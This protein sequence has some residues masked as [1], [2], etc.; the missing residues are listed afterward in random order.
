MFPSTYSVLVDVGGTE[1]PL[2]L[3]TGSSDLWL[4]SDGCHTSACANSGVPLYPLGSLHST[5][6]DAQLLYGD[7]RTGTHASGPIGTDVTGVAG[8][9]VSGQCFAAIADTNTTVLGT[10]SA[11]IFGLGF[12]PVSV[13]WRQL[14]ETD[15]SGAPPSLSRRSRLPPLELTTTNS[16][17]VSTDG[18]FIGRPP[19]PSFTFLSPHRRIRQVKAS[20]SDPSALAIEAFATYG[21]FVTRLIAQQA[22]ASPMVAITLQRDTFE[23]GGNAGLLSLGGP[24]SGVQEDH[25]RWVPV[26]G[27][28]ADEGGLPPA[29]EA[30]NE[31][32]PLLWEIPIDDVYFDG[33]KLPRSTLSAP[34]ISLSALM[35][36]GNSLIRGPQDVVNNILAQLGGPTGSFDCDTPH[37]LSFE[38]GGELFPIDPRDFARPHTA[39]NSAN[40]PRC[41]GAVAATDPPGEGGFLYSWS[42]GDPFLK[43]VL[44]AYY[45]GNLTHPSQDPP[46][47]GFISTVPDDAGE[48]LREAVQAAISAGAIFPATS[49]PAPSGTYMATTTGPGGVPQA[50]HL[51]AS[52]S[53]NARSS[54]AARITDYADGWTSLLVISMNLGAALLG[55]ACL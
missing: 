52:Y 41:T 2:V 44:A 15:I 14:L 49:E 19:F 11:G 25:L 43:S 31:I 4:V 35:D 34:S 16:S 3:D 18:S 55:F 38:I 6:L 21:P 54:N 1:T 53:S 40:S 48:A 36:T 45:Y 29:P 22:L 51:A 37:N 30:P 20:L 33:T 39:N 9:S 24:P 42:L 23:V 27:Y 28:S 7:S 46:R 8:L 47:V 17:S 13:I 5:G 50:T 12:P 10:G 26:R 32:Y